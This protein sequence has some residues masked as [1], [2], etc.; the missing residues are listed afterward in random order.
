MLDGS[1]I[2]LCSVGQFGLKYRSFFFDRPSAFSN[3]TSVLLEC[4]EIKLLEQLHSRHVFVLGVSR[5]DWSGW[6]LGV[7]S[8]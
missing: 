2:I 7:F 4:T 1:E 8:M 5:T 6:E 3:Y